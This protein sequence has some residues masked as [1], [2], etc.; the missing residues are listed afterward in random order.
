VNIGSF[1]VNI[2]K[3]Y[4]F[5]YVE[6]RKVLTPQ[7][8]EAVDLHICKGDDGKCPECQGRCDVTA[9]DL[10]D[11]NCEGATLCFKGSSDEAV[12]GCAEAP[13]RP[14]GK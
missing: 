6:D 11:D 7:T 4:C 1:D 5:D 14:P 3:G 9:S 8:P 10:K 12:P 13:F 2:G